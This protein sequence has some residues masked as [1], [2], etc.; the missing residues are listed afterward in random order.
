MLLRYIN[1]KFPS[2]SY[3]VH[4][5][6]IC[7]CCLGC[8][9]DTQLSSLAAHIS[10]SMRASYTTNESF[11]LNILIPPILDIA[12]MTARSVVY[13]SPQKQSGFPNF[14]ELL[15]RVLTSALKDQF[16]LADLSTGSIRVLNSSYF[17]CNCTQI[18]VEALFDQHAEYAH[19]IM[20]SF[21]AT[22]KRK[23]IGEVCSDKERYDFNQKDSGIQYI[24]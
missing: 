17:F 22:R 24:Y 15:Q 2:S 3:T 8:L 4:D 21:V 12:R 23:L 18:D 11:A 6:A 19:S 20:P 5:S 16:R 7:P 9:S 1:N 13:A 10:A 14:K